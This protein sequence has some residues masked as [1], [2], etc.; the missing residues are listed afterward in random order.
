MKLHWRGM[1]RWSHIFFAAFLLIVNLSSRASILIQENLQQNA[2]LHWE[3][4][5]WM[6]I[7][8]TVSLF[9]HDKVNMTWVQNRINGVRKCLKR[10]AAEAKKNRE[11]INSTL[12]KLLNDYKFQVLSK[13][14]L[15]SFSCPSPKSLNYES[16]DLSKTHFLSIQDLVKFFIYWLIYHHDHSKI[17]P[18]ATLCWLPRS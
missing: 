11:E 17:F 3:L 2:R 1:P 7:E 13:F 8:E 12:Q 14:F 10:I 9:L 6:P 16:F 18:N 15:L 5:W 4:W